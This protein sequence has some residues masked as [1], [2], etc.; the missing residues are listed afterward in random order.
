LFVF[1]WVILLSTTKKSCST[2]YSW[3]KYITTVLIAYM[4]FL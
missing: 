3:T 1:M 2:N 4:K